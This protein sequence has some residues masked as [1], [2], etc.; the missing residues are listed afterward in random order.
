MLPK[1]SISTGS[2]CHY[3]K[4]FGKVFSSVTKTTTVIVASNTEPTCSM[5]KDDTFIGL[6]VTVSLLFALLFISVSAN[7][8][9]LALNKRCAQVSG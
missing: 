5:P 8:I 1:V 7:V 6:S 4:I 3:R 9:F 2:I